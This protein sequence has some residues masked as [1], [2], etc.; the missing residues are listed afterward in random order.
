M[1]FLVIVVL[2]LLDHSWLIGRNQIRN[3]KT[4]VFTLISLFYNLNRMD[5]I[6]KSK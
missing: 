3:I 6:M 5:E 1:K 2:E 4:S